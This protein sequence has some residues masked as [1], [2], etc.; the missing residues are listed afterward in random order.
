LHHHRVAAV[1]A[2]QAQV[3][4]SHL[5]SSHLLSSHLLSS[6][7]SSPLRFVA[8][9]AGASRHAD[10]I[11]AFGDYLV[12]ESRTVERGSLIF[13][14]EDP[15]WLIVSLQGG[16]PGSKLSD[17]IKDMQPVTKGGLQRYE[18][19]A[20]TTLPDGPTAPR[21]QASGR[22]PRRRWRRPCLRSWLSTTRGTNENPTSL[23]VFVAF[24][25]FLQNGPSG[26]MGSYRIKKGIKEFK[27]ELVIFINFMGYGVQLH[28]AS[29][30]R[31]LGAA[32]GLGCKNT[33]LHLGSG[34]IQHH[35][36]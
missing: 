26:G 10:W 35:S 22:V 30:A 21:Q 14:K 25:R 7:L 11:L 9:P 31:I 27:K 16:N 12:F 8:F 23:G 17:Y 28:L 4:P 5:I 34:G 19:V 2:V 32:P 36:T 24:R 18:Q 29:P 13:S 1:Q 6:H 3:C 20:V 33:E 15:A